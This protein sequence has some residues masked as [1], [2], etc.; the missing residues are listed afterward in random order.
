L[1][2]IIDSS[3]KKPT[4]GVEAAPE[5]CRRLKDDQPYESVEFVKNEN[6]SPYM[7]LKNL[8]EPDN[9]YQPLQ[10]PGKRADSG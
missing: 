1:D 4:N 7:D 10:H 6:S 5:R 8:R 3:S 2:S 9:D